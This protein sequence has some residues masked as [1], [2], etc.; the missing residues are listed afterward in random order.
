M[1]FFP[2]TSE[3]EQGYAA[4]AVNVPMNFLPE[5]ILLFG[6]QILFH[7][8]TDLGI[9][10]TNEKGL[11]NR[12]VV[13]VSLSSNRIADS[14]KNKNALIARILPAK[15][16]WSEILACG[17]NPALE[18]IV[19]R[20]KVPGKNSLKDYIR[21]NPPFSL[22]GKLLAVLFHR[23][24]Y[25]KGAY[26]KGLS[27]ISTEQIKSDPEILESIILELAHL[28]NLKPAFLDWIEN[29]NRFKK[30]KRSF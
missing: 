25:Y 16:Q 10:N 23:F 8:I 5:K 27:I 14:L 20:E 18:Y 11:F 6:S 22:P 3:K 28:N 12:S 2:G 7:N 29:A 21:S 13:V 1:R 19:C 24:E 4:S 15:E 17:C 30:N 26:D 9:D